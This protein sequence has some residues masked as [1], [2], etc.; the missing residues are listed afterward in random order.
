MT[1]MSAAFLAEDPIQLTPAMAQD[2]ETSFRQLRHQTKNALQRIL[3]QIAQCRELQ[4][5][6]DGRRL[7]EDLERRVRLSASVSDALF[8]IASAPDALAPRLQRLAQATVDLLGDA[9]QLVRLEVEVEPGCPA[10][11]DQTVLRIVH[12]LVGNAVKH[13]LYARSIGRITVRAAAEGRGL[14]RL[15]VIDDG[16]GFKQQPDHGEGLSLVALL[17]AQHGGTATL[18]RR[19]GA[20][21][22]SVALRNPAA[23]RM[24]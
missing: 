8:G 23:V 11:L 21:V 18:E 14:V 10:A 24:S 2:D 7:V 17:A 4:S 22:A 12:E 3:C 13:G 5:T 1:H 16:W 20:T 15:Q 9:D 6:R 19:G